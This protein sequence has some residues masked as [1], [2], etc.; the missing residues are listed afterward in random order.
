MKM[1]GEV[2]G[3]FR[4]AI[5]QGGINMPM[6]HSVDFCPYVNEAVKIF[7]VSGDCVAL[8]GKKQVVAQFYQD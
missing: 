1:L 6:I 5:T 2:I 8:D 7:P 4:V 3:Q